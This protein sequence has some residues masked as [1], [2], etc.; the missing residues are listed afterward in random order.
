MPI[1]LRM[2]DIIFSFFSDPTFLKSSK[3]T[4]IGAI[5]GKIGIETIDIYT[6]VILQ[7]CGIFAFVATIV[8]ASPKIIEL[9]KKLFKIMKEAF[10]KAINAISTTFKK[11]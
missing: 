5:L 9:H 10:G 1:R 8:V 4:I 11:S 2:N 6:R 7:G 3:L